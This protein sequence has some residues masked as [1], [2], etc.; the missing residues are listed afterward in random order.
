M[1]KIL[2]QYLTICLDRLALALSNFILDIR[3]A[4]KCKS[5]TA[6]LFKDVLQELDQAHVLNVR[7]NAAVST[8][9]GH[10][11]CNCCEETFEGL[12]NSCNQEKRTKDQDISV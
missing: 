2:S 9:L 10:T 1:I 8:F 6:V 7:S 3:L 12:Y 4:G 5:R 11:T